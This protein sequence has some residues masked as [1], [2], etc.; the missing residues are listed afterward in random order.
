MFQTGKSLV[1]LSKTKLFFINIT[2]VLSAGLG[3]TG[4]SRETSGTWGDYDGSE[5]HSVIRS[6][7]IELEYAV[8]KV[9]PNLVTKTDFRLNY[10]GRE[11]QL[12]FNVYDVFG[13]LIQSGY[14]QNEENKQIDVSDLSNG[15]Y[16]LR[17]SGKTIQHSE[18]ILI[19]K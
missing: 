5:H 15:L 18:K 10:R 17:L 6:V 14:I 16:I 12:I 7:Q 13:K 19:S 8:I 11:D 2:F 3:I 1:V 4:E 9:I